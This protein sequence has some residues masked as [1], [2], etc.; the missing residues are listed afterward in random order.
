[1]ALQASTSR[2]SSGLGSIGCVHS[3][4]KGVALTTGVVRATVGAVDTTPTECKSHAFEAVRMKW[5]T[6]IG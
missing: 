6:R 3:S 4:Q 5:Q 1:M 2:R